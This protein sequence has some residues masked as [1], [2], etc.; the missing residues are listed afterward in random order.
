MHP[1]HQQLANDII[2]TLG[3][4]KGMYIPFNDFEPFETEW[5]HFKPRLFAVLYAAGNISHMSF[6]AS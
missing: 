4:H 5:L 3:K 1:L 6:T 2:F